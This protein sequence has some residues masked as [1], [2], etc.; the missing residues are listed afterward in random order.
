MQATPDPPDAATTAPPEPPDAASTTTT[1]RVAVRAPHDTTATPITPRELEAIAAWEPRRVATGDKAAALAARRLRSGGDVSANENDYRSGYRSWRRGNAA[2]ATESSA[3]PVGCHADVDKAPAPAARGP[4]LPAV[5]LRHIVDADDGPRALSHLKEA[6]AHFGKF[7][8]A[9]RGLALRALGLRDAAAARHA[10]T[11]RAAAATLAAPGRVR[12]P[13]WENPDVQRAGTL[14][15]RRTSQCATSADAAA[16]WVAAPCDAGPFAQDLNGSWRFELFDSP[17]KALEFVERGGAAGDA[18]DVPGAWQTLGYD[19]PVYTNIQYPIAVSTPPSMPRRNTS[20]VYARTVVP[21][22]AAAAGVLDG[23]RRCV[24]HFGAADNAAFVFAGGAW[25]ALWKDARLP[26]EVDVTEALREALGRGDDGLEV[27]CVVVRWTEGSYLEDQDAWKLSGLIRDVYALYPPAVSVFDISWELAGDGAVAVAVDVA[28]VGRAMA[29]R[30]RVALRA[31]GELPLEASRAADHGGGPVVAEREAPL[32]HTTADARRCYEDDDAVEAASSA[33]TITLRCDRPLKVW[34]PERPYVYVLTVELLDDAQTVLQAEACYVARRDVA[35]GNDG[36]LRL[37]GARLTVAGVNRHETCPVRGGPHVRRDDAENDAALLKA[38][39]FN[40][41]RLSHYPQAPAFYAA[42]D[43]C[44]LLVVDEANVETHGWAPYPGELADCARWREAYFRRVQ[45]MVLRDRS[46]PCVFCFSL[47]N[48]AGYGGAHDDLAA[49][50]RSAEPTRLV[51][52]EP[53]SWAAYEADA[54]ALA[55]AERGRRDAA[56]PPAWVEPPGRYDRS[57]VSRR[58]TAT[59][60]LC[61]MY[62]RV[63]ECAALLDRDVRVLQRKRP[64]I[65]CEYAHAMG[66][67]GGNLA[68]Y[69][70]AF[71]DPDMPRLQGGFIWDLADQG[72]RKRL[73]AH[74]SFWAYGGDFGELPTDETFC[75]N[76]LLFPDRSPKPSWLEAAAVQRPFGDPEVVGVEARGAARRLVVRVPSRVSRTGVEL[77]RRFEFSWRLE[78][79]GTLIAEAPPKPADHEAPRDARDRVRDAALELGPA[80]R[81][82]AD[83]PEEALRTRRP[84]KATLTVAAFLR[85]D[86]AWA[87]RGAEVA[88]AQVVLGD[89]V[90]GPPGAAPPAAGDAFGLRVVSATAAEIRVESRCGTVGVTID[91]DTALPVGYDVNGEAALLSETPAASGGPARRASS[92]RSGSKAPVTAAAVD[93]RSALALAALDGGGARAPL[94]ADELPV[95]EAEVGYGEL[96][97]RGK[98]GYEGKPVV[99]GG[100]PRRRSLSAHANSVVVLDLGAAAGAG[101]FSR[102]TGRVAINDDQREDSIGGVVGRQSPLVFEVRDAMKKVLWS[103][104]ATPLAEPGASQALDADL[105]GCGATLELRVHSPWGPVDVAHAVWVDPLLWWAPPDDTGAAAPPSPGRDRLAAAAK[106]YAKGPVKLCCERAFTDNDRGGYAA[107]WRAAGLDRPLELARAAPPA[108][109]GAVGDG[110]G[111]ARLRRLDDG[112]LEFVARLEFRPARADAKTLALY[113]RLDAWHGSAK[114]G[115]REVLAPLDARATAAAHL[116]AAARRLAHADVP[117]GVEVWVP[118]VAPCSTHPLGSA[119]SAAQ[120][121]A[122]DDDDEESGARAAPSPRPPGDA[123]VATCE[124]STR[125]GADGS[126][127][128]SIAD[129]IF[130]TADSAKA[131]WPPLPRLG[132][133]LRL[134]PS[135]GD[136]AWLGLGPHECYPDR[137]A[138]ALFG[139]FGGTVDDLFVPYLRPSECGNRTGVERLAL[140]SPSLALGIAADFGA[141]DFSAGRHGDRDL[142]EARHQHELGDGRS[143]TFQTISVVVRSFRLSFGRARDDLDAYIRNNH[144]EATPFPRPG[145]GGAVHVHVDRAVQGVGGDDSWTACVHEPYLVVPPP[146]EAPAAFRFSLD[147]VPRDADDA[148][149]LLDAVDGTSKKRVGMVRR[150]SSGSLDDAGLA[151][152]F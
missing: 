73:G 57:G 123:L 5:N 52:Y 107:A 19:T 83:V 131:A 16:R 145:D 54:A 132:L 66:N 141:F 95:L 135:V 148:R 151:P 112:S 96:G 84:G 146:P 70:A 20:G 134:P 72:L 14:R 11:R 15:A 94:H 4:K 37:N 130:R 26:G 106:R 109:L 118:R 142:V 1:P 68:D 53:A 48:E 43:R 111:A 77:A 49:W 129:L 127:T 29:G 63:D 23:S 144:V 126:V 113:A 139:A 22:A 58:Q 136:V 93:R 82:A 133:A 62:A 13:P 91:A 12:P 7:L 105:R 56:G 120:E 76:G 55:P 21:G 125:V 150:S 34:S 89:D 42:C 122:M 99:V 35:I 117:R 116:W 45:R 10:A 6:L 28:A 61:P 64:L 33:Q 2:G 101:S 46:H 98:L 88:R 79:A 124:A 60:F 9:L 85:R 110:G 137:K 36:V 102:L 44:G 103:N 32:V 140:A 138:A 27:V 87:P 121:K 69:W 75:L 39:H 67:S 71:R 80:A 31:A 50:L 149:P 30:L 17:M 147:A 108:G 51:H 38:G 65:L 97:F 18:I 90:L 114:P 81:V 25:R 24:L 119:I 74:L 104:A 115:D 92:F 3:G 78:S 100:T 143:G 47:G 152:S 41:V 40:C 8:R 86:E 59:D 128:V